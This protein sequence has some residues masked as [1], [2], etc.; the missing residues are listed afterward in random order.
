MK[1]QSQLKKLFTL[2]GISLII[3]VVL[4]FAMTITDISNYADGLTNLTMSVGGLLWE[5]KIW[6]TVKDNT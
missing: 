5:E 1:K 2:L 6:E 4:I 3:S